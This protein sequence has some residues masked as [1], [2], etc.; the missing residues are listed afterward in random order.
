[1][2]PCARKQE[3]GTYTKDANSAP[4]VFPWSFT[5]SSWKLPWILSLIANGSSSPFHLGTS[6]LSS[7]GPVAIVA[8]SPPT[9]PL[10]LAVVYINSEC[11]DKAALLNTRVS[12][13]FEFATCAAASVRRVHFSL[14]L[15]WYR[16]CDEWTMPLRRVGLFRNRRKWSL[17]ENDDSS[18][19]SSVMYVFFV[20][21]YEKGEIQ[22]LYVCLISEALF[23]KAV[24][25][26]HQARKSWKE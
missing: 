12:P 18:C 25:V 24:I 6:S 19:S 23:I 11:A 10:Y 22:F 7:F 26:L 16:D 4:P 9:E 15:G 17:G 1:M 14:I 3:V 20:K 21:F 5:V 2:V 13:S 8:K